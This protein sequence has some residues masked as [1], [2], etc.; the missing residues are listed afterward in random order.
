MVG[1]GEIKKAVIALGGNAIIREG[2]E[3]TIAQQFKN[4]RMSLVGVVE[5]IKGGWEVLLTHGNGPQ[6]G[7]RVISNEVAQEMVPDLP[8][9]VL[10]GDTEGAMGYMIQQSLF[11]K[12]TY[13]SIKRLVVTV[14]TQSVVDSGNSSKIKPTKP[15]GLFYSEEEKRKLEVERN[16]EFVE[17]SGRGYRQVVSSPV[18][19]SIVEIDVIK[20]LLESGVIV[21]AVGGG[22]IPVVRQPDG[23]LE[24][25]DGIIDKDLASSLAARELGADIF[26]MITGEPQVSLN[27]RKPN[28]KEIGKMTRDEAEGFL[29]EGHFPLGSMGPKMRAAIEYLEARKNGKV[30][31]TSPEVLPA[32]IIGRGGTIICN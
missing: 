26:V 8:L 14:I 5:L 7:N 24:G 4:T 30:I 3:G 9:G 23:T 2:E 13:H 10:C 25:V 17:D 19:L 32:A 27:Y 6:V 11:N 1:K 21:I 29:E 20:L 22:G 18:P 28:Q 15:I 12:L 31:I 16:W